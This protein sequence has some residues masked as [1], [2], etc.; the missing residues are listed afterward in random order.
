VQAV[1]LHSSHGI[2][3]EALHLRALGCNIVIHCQAAPEICRALAIA[4]GG[5]QA[6]SAPDWANLEYS[7]R[8]TASGILL[9]ADATPTRAEDIGE[10]VYLLDKSITLA[11]QR[12]RADLCFLHSGAVVAPNGRVIVLTA[13]SGSGKSTLTWALLHHG[14]GYLSDEL[15][16]IDPATLLVHGY[17]HALC[18]KRKPP[19]PYH[20][21][22]A[23]LETSH[24]LH[25]PVAATAEQGSLAAIFFVGHRHPEN[26][27]ILSDVNP[28]RAALHLYANTLN[29]LA[30]PND[31]LD[32]IAEIAQQVP[33]YALNSANLGDA[34]AALQVL[35]ENLR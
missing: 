29:P 13:A 28:A 22:S 12:I 35:L 32:V 15:A 11:L 3:G 27:P 34:C 6:A 7:V 31:G 17:P 21:P 1:A 8:Q 19:E 5:M 18:L 26:H 24:T 20:L 23:T 2:P 30:H 4:F 25:V 33:S 16:P 14:F 10:L 9:E